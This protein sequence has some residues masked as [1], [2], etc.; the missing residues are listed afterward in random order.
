MHETTTSTRTVFRGRVLT[1]EVLDI[2]LPGGR[3]TTREVVRHPGAVA[4]VAQLPDGRFVF[5]R[6][7]RKAI[8]HETLELVAGTLHPGE[9]PRA[10]AV[11]EIREETGYAVRDLRDMGW[12]YLAPGYSDEKLFLFYAALAATPGGT[13]PDDDEDVAT[14]VLTE[15]AVEDL[16]RRG[17]IHDAKTLAGWLAWSRTGAAR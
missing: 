17:E 9:D 5:V 14:V 10:C 4:A 16:L 8:D 12:I 3:R 2:E 1:L 6:Q 15:A 7:F 13:S 11:R